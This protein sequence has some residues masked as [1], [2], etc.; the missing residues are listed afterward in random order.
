MIKFWRSRFSLL[1]IG[2]AL[3]LFPLL[4]SW[5]ELNNQ[6]SEDL[7]A[8][9]SRELNLL[10]NLFIQESNVSQLAAEELLYDYSALGIRITF[11]ADDGVVLFDSALT[12]EELQ[13][14]DNH[15]NRQEVLAAKEY[16]QAT[17]SRYS[18]TLASDLVY[19]A[20]VISETKSYPQGTLRLA[21]P[22]ENTLFSI[23]A[24]LRNFLVSFCLLLLGAIIL[25][26]YLYR[27]FVLSLSQIQTVVENVARPENNEKLALPQKPEFEELAYAV[28]QMS[29]RVD[30][31]IHINVSQ[32]SELET[33]FNSLQA[34]VMVLD[35]RGYILKLNA[36]FAKLLPTYFTKDLASYLDKSV[37]GVLSDSEVSEKIHNMYK[38]EL[39]SDSME[40]QLNGQIFQLSLV[41]P[42]IPNG[43]KIEAALV[44]I[45]HDITYLAQLIQIKREL[46]ANVSHELRTPLTAIQGY[47]ETL[48]SLMED[49]E[50]PKKQISHF[51]ETIIKNTK[52]LDRVVSD[53]LSLSSVENSEFENGENVQTTLGEALNFALDECKPLLHNKQITIEN[54]LAND[55]TVNIDSDR[56]SQVFRNLVEN[57][58]RYSPEG[59]T[60]TLYSEI[61]R[62]DINGHSKEEC[63]VYVQDYGI[64]IPQQE[65]TRV[66]E[67]FYRVEK[68]RTDTLSTGLGLSICKHIIEKY[69]GSINALHHAEN[70]SSDNTQQVGATIRF[71]LPVYITK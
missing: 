60:I 25:N 14:L 15:A 36:A 29:E 43:I 40:I 37:L 50:C 16:G 59:K 68:H 24:L 27:R 48:Q 17:S 45:F 13:A 65:L 63:N 5:Q 19:A 54:K 12:P 1:I 56:L 46:V 3:L 28:S 66:F 10:S 18:S 62:N 38:N 51:L 44:L 6:I 4:I 67:R 42:E 61:T 53:L 57:A 8:T 33:I 49:E 55:L 11:I 20:S 34:G 26:F 64:G 21:I 9:T 35:A 71:T 23:R 58:I 47:T 32:S 22:L 7:K 52:H 30:E 70:L 31:Q 39:T 2:F 41:K 69:H